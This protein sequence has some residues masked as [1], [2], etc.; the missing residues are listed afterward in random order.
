MNKL[1][2]SF[3]FVIGACALN[4]Q[5]NKTDIL[6]DL[7]KNRVANPAINQEV[8]VTATLKSASRLFREK[9]D[10]TSVIM[11]LPAG[12]VVEILDSDSTYYKVQYEDSEGYILR[13]HA[14]I[15]EA[16][17]AAEPAPEAIDTVPVTTEQQPVQAQQPVQEQEV[18]RFTYLENKYGSNMAAKLMSGKIWK[19]MDAEMIRDSWGN[20]R[21]INRV[22]SG[23]IIKEE[24]IFR[25][26]WLYIEN[27]ILKD[28]GP[29]K[30]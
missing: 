3:L 6:Q 16:A 23:N 10:L 29:I 17:V 1:I 20:P 9:D 25:N 28:W 2:F 24:W 22:I 5:E 8:N 7:E 15:N 12:S 27:D 4:A 14:V 30:N 11:V 19:G 21:K 26:T 13:R 18:S